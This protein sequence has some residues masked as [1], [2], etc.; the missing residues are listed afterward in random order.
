M[1]NEIKRY[2]VTVDYVTCTRVFVDA[3]DEEHA[4]EAIYAYLDTPEGLQDM[5]N[6]MADSPNASSDA[7]EVAYV[8]ESKAIG[9]DTI[10]AW[11]YC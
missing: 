10:K 5:L 9:S 8:G 7:F 11:K 6:R 3:F 4:E 1:S 2:S